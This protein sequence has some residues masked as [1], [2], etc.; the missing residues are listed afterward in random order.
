MTV[1]RFSNELGSVVPPDAKQ[2]DQRD[3]SAALIG[4][5]ALSSPSFSQ[6]IERQGA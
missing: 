5:C 1:K 2:G 4:N 6:S 3:Q